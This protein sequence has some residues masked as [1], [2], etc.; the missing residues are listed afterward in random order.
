MDMLWYD[1]AWVWPGGQRG[2]LGATGE[3]NGL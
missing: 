2:S 3:A 1:M